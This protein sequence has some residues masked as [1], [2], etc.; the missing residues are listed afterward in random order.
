[1]NCAYTIVKRGVSL[2]PKSKCQQTVQCGL[3]MDENTEFI[4]NHNGLGFS[5]V[6]NGCNYLRLINYLSFNI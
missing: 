6:T 3:W 4:I 5:P 1:M 2:A